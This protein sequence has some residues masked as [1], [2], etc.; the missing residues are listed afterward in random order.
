MVPIFIP[1]LRERLEDLP[2]LC[3]TLIRRFNQAYGR[4]VTC[5]SQHAIDALSDYEWPGNVRELENVLS[6]AMINMH[7]SDIE[8]LPEHLPA[9][10][11]LGSRSGFAQRFQGSEER[12]VT[13]KLREAVKDAEV[14]EIRKALEVAGGNRRIAAE[15]LGIGVRSLYYKIDRYNIK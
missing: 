10:D 11:R 1:P 7:Y 6:R 5:I 14:K 3:Q 12:T 2:F 4:N 13:R 8:I 9:L 15:I